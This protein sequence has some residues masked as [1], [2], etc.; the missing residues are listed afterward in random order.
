MRAVQ[1]PGRSHSSASK[2][3]FATLTLRA[4]KLTRHACNLGDELAD[5]DK[6]SDGKSSGGEAAGHG[7]STLERMIFPPR[8]CS[9]SNNFRCHNGQEGVGLACALR[10]VCVSFCV[11]W[12]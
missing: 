8:N 2:V 6:S 3:V 12:H 7:S 5:M 10:Y 11:W 4:P 1:W 9:S